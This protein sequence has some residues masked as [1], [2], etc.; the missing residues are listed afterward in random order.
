MYNFLMVTVDE[1]LNATLNIRLFG[2]LE[3]ALGDV[4]VV[5]PTEKARALL[6]YLAVEREH[7]QRRDALAGLL[8]PDQPERKARHS[9]RQALSHLRRVIGDQDRSEDEGVLFLDVSRDT[10]HLN[11]QAD[12]WADVLAFSELD[13][14]NAAHRHR[15]VGTCR[16][17]LYRLE[18]MVALYRAPFLTQFFLGDSPAFEEWV[19][20]TREWL[21]RPAMDALRVLA[22][23]Y[24]R[25]GDLAQARACALRQVTLDPWRE[26]AHRRL[27]RLLAF[28]GQRSAALAQYEAC[29]RALAQELGVEPTEETRALYAAI[30]DGDLSASASPG[31]RSPRHN[32]PS[33]ATSFVGRQTELLEIADLLA[34][35]D[36]RMLALV[37]PGGIGK[38]RLALQVAEEHRGLFEHGVYTV[39]LASVRDPAFVVSAIVQALG[40]PVY[41]QQEL[42]AQLVSYLRAREM[43]LVLDNVEHLAACCDWLSELLRDAPQLVLLLTSRERPD[44]REAWIYEV[45]GLGYPEADE[46]ARGVDAVPA[47]DAVLVTDAVELFV[48]RAQQVD[49]HFALSAEGMPGV[50]P[51]V[52][53]I[54]RLVE[55]MPL[56]LELAAAWMPQHTCAEIAEAIARNLDILVSTFRNAPDRHRS[57]RAAF[58]HSYTLL[59]ER[60]RAVFQGL[61]LFHGGFDRTAAQAVLD[62]SADELSRLCRK[63]LVR[64]LPSG[65]YQV[66]QLLRQYAEEQLLGDDAARYAALLARHADHYAHVVQA[67]EVA[68]KGGPAQLEALHEIAVEIDN[69]RAA[70]D[71]AVAQVP[72]RAA[73]DVLRTALQGLYLFYTMHDW[74]QEGERAFARAVAALRDCSPSD[75]A[76]SE[77]CDLLVARLLVRQGKCCEFTRH[78]ARAERLFQEALD[79]FE[80]LGVTGERALALL[81]LG[82]VAHQRGEYAEAEARFEAALVLYKAVGD[83]WGIANTLSNL[84]LVARRRG[85]FS[86]AKD[87]ALESLAIRRDV[88]DRRGIA[89]SLSNLGLVCCCMGEYAEAQDV[90]LESL[91]TYRE[92]DYKTGISNALSGLCQVE[93]YKDDLAAA[94]AYAQES[95]ALYREVGDRWGAA[96]SLNN[97]GCMALELGAYPEAQR[98]LRESIA[99]YEEVGVMSGLANALSNLGEACRHLGE[100]DE[101]GRHLC[102]ALRIAREIDARPIALEILVRLAAL[103][104]AR[105]ELERPLV[106][107]AF[108]K[109]DPACLDAVKPKAEA[110]FV[111]L[112]ERNAEEVV[113]RASAQAQDARF[114]EVVDDALACWGRRDAG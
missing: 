64:R 17:C 74:Y 55:G 87:Y 104:V 78:N 62:A 50:L 109:Q 92:I 46:A 102:A 107:L 16:R 75:G 110:A 95:L 114:E 108:V 81:G 80:R 66:H 90:L 68:L 85:D 56:G 88:G 29:R 99:V 12:V 22:A 76:T 57:V 39:S 61:A 26:E 91:A 67:R 19:L 100:L 59:S 113:A 36:C 18:R 73:L 48:Q 13:A 84:S 63:S 5:F 11:P 30:R 86:P 96:I 97:L 45:E 44:L 94:Q 52:L 2:A 70:W 111:A 89:S 21:H 101:A 27:M 33:T 112:R 72:A 14:Q 51:D 1:T 25:R 77:A 8:W 28:E 40:V 35:P 79:R 98:R 38:T 4:P 106:W 103:C 105:G 71:W 49:R 9:L 31:G 41:G 37:G 93:F 7:P 83:R 34:N 43:L 6:A 20:V 54:C 15:R 69:V 58:A 65:R 53:R 24:E 3:V 32:L 60:E 10:V 23:Y 42:K 82:Y 47:T